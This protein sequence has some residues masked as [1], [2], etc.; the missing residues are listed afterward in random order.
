MTSATSATQVCGFSNCLYQ[1]HVAPCSWLLQGQWHTIK[2]LLACSK[3]TLQ[4]VSWWKNGKT[5]FWVWSVEALANR[6]A[7]VFSS[8]WSIMDSPR[9]WNSIPAGRLNH[10]PPERFPTIP[11]SLSELY[12]D[13]CK[14]DERATEKRKKY[15]NTSRWLKGGLEENMAS[16]SLS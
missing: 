15:K 8:P 9:Q 5:V 4:T 13:R 7:P 12:W 10:Q 1:S 6:K 3:G 11:H 16:P 14:D 2:S